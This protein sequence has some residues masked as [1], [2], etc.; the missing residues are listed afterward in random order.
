VPLYVKGLKEHDGLTIDDLVDVE[1]SNAISLR[2]EG[3][4]NEE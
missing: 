3:A 1:R 4:C 2:A